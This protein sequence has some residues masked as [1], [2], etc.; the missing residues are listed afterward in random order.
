ME[1]TQ[2]TN[3]TATL[4]YQ[5][6]KYDIVKA[7]HLLATTLWTETSSSWRDGRTF[8]TANNREPKPSAGRYQTTGYPVLVA[9]NFSND[10]AEEKAAALEFVNT[11]T[12]TMADLVTEDGNLIDTLPVGVRLKIVNNRHIIGEWITV[13]AEREAERQAQIARHAA[14][15]Q[16]RNAQ[17]TEIQDM[18]EAL[19]ALGIQR[20]GSDITGNPSASWTTRIDTETLRKLIALAQQAAQS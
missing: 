17:R 7:A 5:P 20:T 16:R 8:R 3:A 2:L 4:A 14:D 11:T 1:K 10:S 15:Q 6:S 19:T 9:D 12:L 18:N 13:Q